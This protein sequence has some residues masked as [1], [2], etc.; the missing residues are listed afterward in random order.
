MES[1]SRLLEHF[2]TLEDPRAEY[3]LEHQLLDIIGLTICAVICGADTWVD[4]EQYGKAKESWLSGFLELPNG[5]PSH[6]TIARLFAALNPAALQDCFL[7]WVKAIAQLSEGEVMAIDGKTLRH[8]YGQG[9]RKGAIHMVSAWA[10]QNRLVLGQEKVDEKPNEITAIPQLLKVL[11]LNG[12]IVTIDALAL[13]C[14][15]LRE[16]KRRL[17]SRLLLVVGT[18]Y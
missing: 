12:C 2:Q 3:L 6:D 11:D 17:P 15:R 18:M 7:S 9:G 5:I 10:S 4:I 14:R 16:R 8:S 1:S 13:A